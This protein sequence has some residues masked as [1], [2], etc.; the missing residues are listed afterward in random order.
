M[1]ILSWSP[2]PNSSTS[3]AE[4]SR[5][6]FVYEPGVP[7]SKALLKRL[8]RAEDARGRSGDWVTRK[9]SHHGPV[10]VSGQWVAGASFSVRRRALPRGPGRGVQA[11]QGIQ[12][13]CHCCTRTLLPVSK[14]VPLQSLTKATFWPGQQTSWLGQYFGAQGVG[15]LSVPHTGGPEF[16]GLCRGC[17]GSDSGIQGG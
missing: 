4:G 16:T 17:N 2:R 13:G 3:L 7:G 6:S 10:V 9:L 1:P 15:G 11:V 8:V 12:R 5:G 14:P